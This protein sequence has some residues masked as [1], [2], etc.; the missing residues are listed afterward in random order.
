MD[1]QKP[2]GSQHVRSAQ[3]ESRAAHP[4]AR[5]SR[6]RDKKWMIASIALIIVMI[7]GGGLWFG[8]DKLNLGGGPDPNTYQA[9]FLTNGQVYFGKLS[10]VDS[11]YV[12]LRD[13]YYL[14]VQQA[15]QPAAKEEDSA[16]TKTSLV[17]LGDELHAP[18]DHMFIS[19]DQVLFWE[20]I[21]DSGKVAQAIKAQKEKK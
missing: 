12:Q 20:D 18:K 11:G 3:A 1:I 8:K 9:L 17:K 16:E 15:V 5:S 19:R 14:Q 13:I 6:P 2:T 10:N 7:I 4:T 21:Q